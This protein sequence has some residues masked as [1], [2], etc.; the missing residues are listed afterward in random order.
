MGSADAVAALERAGLRVAFITN[1]SSGRVEDYVEQA[2]G[3]GSRRRP[4]RRLHE[5]TGGRQRARSTTL[6]PGA[7]VLACAGPGVVQA[8]VV[9][10]F[11][12][13][14]Q[15]PADAVVVGFHREFDFDA[16]D[17]CRRRGARPV[18]ASSRR[19]S[20]RRTRSPGGLE[21][22]AGAL[23]AAVATAAGARPEVAGKPEVATVELVRE[24]FG[25]VG[26]VVGDRP[27][28]DGALAARVG[29]AVRTRA[30][31]CR[32][33]G[34]RGTGSRSA[35]RLRRRRPRATRTPPR[36]RLRTM[37]QTD[38]VGGPVLGCSTPRTCRTLGPCDDFSRPRCSVRP[39]WPRPPRARSRPRRRPATPAPRP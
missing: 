6:E 21:P 13:V 34:P 10:G 37:T 1:N 12:V 24:R 19:T 29:L 23:V 4:R 32:G 25:S 14:D 28:T 39:W 16:L 20:T 8:L 27:S 15:G 18:P 9:R 31:G 5:C 22:G 3:D 36:R 7:R 26:V 2:R 38:Q 17:P 11:E 35:A 33:S 30:L